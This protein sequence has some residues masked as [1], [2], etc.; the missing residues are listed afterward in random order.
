MV[1]LNRVEMMKKI[2]AQAQKLMVAQQAATLAK[3]EEEQ[4]TA[5]LIRLNGSTT[6]NLAEESRHFFEC[7]GNMETRLKYGRDSPALAGSPEQPKCAAVVAVASYYVDRK[8]KRPE[9]TP[10]CDDCQNAERLRKS[11]EEPKA[12]AQEV[13]AREI[14]F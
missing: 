5:E 4:A 13:E 10:I 14:P 1:E 3:I 9:Q 6:V 8:T 12:V 2:F 11:D 7:E